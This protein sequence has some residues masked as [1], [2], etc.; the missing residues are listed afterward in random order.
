MGVKKLVF[1][2]LV[3]NWGMKMSRKIEEVFV[4]HP[5]AI[6]FFRISP[7]GVFQHPRLVSPVIPVSQEFS[8][9]QFF[10]RFEQLEVEVGVRHLQ[11]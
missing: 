5:D 1:L 9:R 7:E 8:A 6:L 4:G 11:A 3:E 10:D 2:K